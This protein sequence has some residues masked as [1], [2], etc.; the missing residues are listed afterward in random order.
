MYAATIMVRIP[1]ADSTCHTVVLK[2]HL[3]DSH[4]NKEERIIA[5]LLI[6]KRWWQWRYYL[7]FRVFRDISLCCF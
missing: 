6:C 3:R 2:Y 1:N 5:G 4:G 7:D